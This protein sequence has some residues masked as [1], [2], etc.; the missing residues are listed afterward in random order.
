MGGERERAGDKR[1]DDGSK[2]FIKHHYMLLYY[3]RNDAS[4]TSQLNVSS[5]AQ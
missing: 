3:I 2:L 1:D 5:S 4:F